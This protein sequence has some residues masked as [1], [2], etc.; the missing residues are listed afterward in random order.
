MRGIRQW[1][2]SAVVLALGGTGVA[3]TPAPLPSPLAAP[4]P[5]AGALPGGAVVGSSIPIPPAP[6]ATVQV[7]TPYVA[8]TGPSGPTRLQTG[9]APGGSL[10]P[11]PAAPA[12]GR[13]CW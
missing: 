10:V 9:P 1:L 12:R 13:M 6:I 5:A 3:Q 2:T 8:P 7:Q 11:G 4:P